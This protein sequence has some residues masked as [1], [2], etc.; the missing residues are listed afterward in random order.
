MSKCGLLCPNQ[1]ISIF[2]NDHDQVIAKR[3]ALT[4]TVNENLAKLS[5]DEKT[6]QMLGTSKKKI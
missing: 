2:S 5:E 1:H 6:H 3:N 4:K